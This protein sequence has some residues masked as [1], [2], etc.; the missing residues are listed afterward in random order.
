MGVPVIKTI[1]DSADIVTEMCKVCLVRSVKGPNETLR[2]LAKTRLL[3]AVARVS[4]RV[5]KL[6]F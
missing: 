5:R 2:A 1:V 3:S 6:H 4:P